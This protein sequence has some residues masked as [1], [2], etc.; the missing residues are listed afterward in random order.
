MIRALG[1]HIK[2]RKEQL[3]LFH[4][5][6]RSQY[7]DRVWYWETRGLS[8]QRGPLV[9]LICDG[10]DQAKFELPRHGMMKSKD[11]STM[12]RVKVHVAACIAHGRFVLFVVSSPDTKKDS[13]A[14]IEMLSY[15]LTLLARQ[16]LH[17]PS[18]DIVLQHDNTSRE[19]KNNGA[20]R[21]ACSQVSLI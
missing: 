18:T 1:A 12:Q 6:L 10:M 15:A 4:S 11:F 7:M 9:T 20:L 14:S 19:F 8:R 17:L 13:N 2:A 5:H 21:W 16:G 3:R